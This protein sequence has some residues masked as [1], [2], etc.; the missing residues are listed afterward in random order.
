[1]KCPHCGQEHPDKLIE[2]PSTGNK[3]KKACSN[4]ECSYRGEYIWPLEKESCPCCGHPLT[5]THQGHE[6]IDLGLSVNWAT[7]NIGANT[8]E[9]YGDYFVWGDARPKSNYECSNQNH[10]NDNNTVFEQSDDAAYVNWGGRWRMP[11][12]DEFQELISNCTWIWMNDKNGYKVVSRSNGNSIF[13]PAAGRYDT[14]FFNT[15]SYGLYWSSS[16]DE[17][18]YSNNAPILF[19][20]SG[21]YTIYNF[22]RSSGLSIR[23]VYR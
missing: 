20:F 16:L 21:G 14:S 11:T 19:F 7:C 1:M 22:F 13:L 10:C 18:D 2:C 3:L 17:S 15:G 4:K 23:P 5:I 8:P 12:K 9:E 6:F